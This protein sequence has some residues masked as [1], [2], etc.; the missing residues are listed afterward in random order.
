MVSFNGD[1][2]TDLAAGVD[3][4]PL[5]PCQKRVARLCVAGRARKEIARELALSGWTVKAHL[6]DIKRALGGDEHVSILLAA[7]CHAALCAHCRSRGRRQA[8][9]QT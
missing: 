4:L 8:S 2:G 1:E 5:T 3:L 9:A 6:R 7:A